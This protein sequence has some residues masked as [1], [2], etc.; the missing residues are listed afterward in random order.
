MAEKNKQRLDSRRL[1]MLFAVIPRKKGPFYIDYLHSFEVNFQ[2]H[3]LAKGTAS[4]EARSLIGLENSD[5]L[6]ICAIIREDRIKE[7][8]EGLE[9]KFASIKNGKGI[10]WTVPLLSVIGASTYGFLSNT[11]TLGNS[12]AGVKK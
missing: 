9:E 5:R 2:T 7:A 1:Y 8:L 12:K 6:L 10:A 11:E 3:F 4:A